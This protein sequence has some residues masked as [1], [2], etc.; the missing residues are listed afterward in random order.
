[1]PEV[2]GLHLVTDDAILARPHFR[3]QAC[4]AM[5]AGGPALA[6]HVRGPSTPARR[7]YSL[8]QELRDPAEASGTLLVVND[9]V[10]IALAA[11][12]RGAHL[13]ERSLPVA[14]ARRILGAGVMVGSSVHDPSAAAAAA[15]DGSAWLFVGT[16]FR[17]PSHPHRAGLGSGAIRQFAVAAHV[18]IIGIGGITVGHVGE[19]RLA[20]AHGVA[21]I[22][23]VWDAVDPARAVGDYLF[24]LA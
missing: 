14:E 1:M 8:V 15:A 16:I 12:L 5:E 17:T 4:A 10:D 19:L 24:S 9:R 20:G 6:L 22:R 7:L 13:G 21:V 11:A 18:P 23:G 3:D 2:P